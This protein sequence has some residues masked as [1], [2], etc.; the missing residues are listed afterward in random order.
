[1]EIDSAISQ[2]MPGEAQAFVEEPSRKLALFAIVGLLAVFLASVLFTPPDAQYFTICGFKNFTGLP[3]PGCGLTH[4]FCALGKG[5][6]INAFA[7]NW[8]G[9]LLFLV[10]VLL[11]IRSACVLLNKTGVVQRLDRIAGRFNT[12]KAFAI[13]FVVYGI[14]RIV[15][16]IAYHP[17]TFRDSPLSQLIMR[18]IP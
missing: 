2:P 3:C 4:S 14:A 5:E 9:P 15:Y 10:L 18:L 12:V 7:F 13:G 6:F 8:L 1:M 11:W 17:A 16:L